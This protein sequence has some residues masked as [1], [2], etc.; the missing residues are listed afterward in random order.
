MYKPNIND[1]RN[2]STTCKCYDKRKQHDL[3]KTKL[4]RITLEFLEKLTLKEG[5]LDD[6]LKF[7]L[8]SLS[9]QGHLFKR[10]QGEILIT[11]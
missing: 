2:P 8:L 3:E 9:V 10:I 11:N 1:K 5:T 6:R 4:V 7:F